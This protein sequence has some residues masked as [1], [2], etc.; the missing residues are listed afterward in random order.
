MVRRRRRAGRE[1]TLRMRDGRED[2]L[3]EGQ[4][5][6]GYQGERRRGAGRSGVERSDEAEEGNV[7]CASVR[8]SS[9]DVPDCP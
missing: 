4:N 9:D 3:T 1:H 6:R 5:R 7:C 2:K 8:E